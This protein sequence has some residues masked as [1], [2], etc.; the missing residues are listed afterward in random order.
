M[1]QVSIFIALL[2]FINLEKFKLK[3]RLFLPSHRTNNVKVTV[4]V[5]SK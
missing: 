5:I 2:K 4:V 1:S 3:T